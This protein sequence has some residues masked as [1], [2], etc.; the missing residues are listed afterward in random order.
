MSVRVIFG[1][2][3]VTA[4][5]AGCGGTSS[6]GDVRGARGCKPGGV[7]AVAPEA[8]VA[9]A[10]LAAFRAP[11]RGLIERFGLLNV[12]RFPTVFGVLAEQVDRSCDATWLH[13]QLPLRPNGVTGWV[14]ADHVDRVPV[15]S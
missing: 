2:G 9:T 7:R 13:V 15:Q 5:L 6:S 4:A 14:R 8:A 11:G 12:N 1:I 3:V 10:P